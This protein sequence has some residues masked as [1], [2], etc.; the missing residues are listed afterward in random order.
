MIIEN[1]HGGGSA[2]CCSLITHEAQ[3]QGIEADAHGKWETIITAPKVAFVSVSEYAPVATRSGGLPF[4]LRY[5][6]I[7]LPRAHRLG[8]RARATGPIAFNARHERIDVKG[9]ESLPK[10]HEF[11][12][13]YAP[14]R[15]GSPAS[16]PAGACQIT[17]TGVPGL[18]PVGGAFIS[19]VKGYRSLGSP[20]FQ[21]CANTVYSLRGTHTNASILL[22]AEHPGT[23]PAALPDMASIGAGFYEAP[24]GQTFIRG[25]EPGLPRP[26]PGEK[27]FTAKR[28]NGAWLVTAGGTQAQRLELLRHIHATIHI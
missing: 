26:A 6:I 23:T 17:A 10:R 15:W 25:I 13:P 27:N 2:G 28:I 1:S 18:A 21:S 11:E 3:M 24:G 20:A 19:R 9:F 22:D 16:P 12:G 4:G 14:R 7:N 5:A 8:A